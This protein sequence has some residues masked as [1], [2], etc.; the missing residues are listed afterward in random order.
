MEMSDLKKKDTE[1][2][3][4]LGKE[5]RES[6]RAFRFGQ[7]GSRARDVKQGRTLRRDIARVE[8]ELTARRIAH[9]QE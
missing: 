7:A 5:L 3:V 8:T 6:L 9:E 1:S 2:L 4:T